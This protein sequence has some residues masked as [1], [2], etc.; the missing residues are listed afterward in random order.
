MCICH[1]Q[2]PME[3]KLKL[4]KKFGPFSREIDTVALFRISKDNGKKLKKDGKRI[5]RP[6]KF[7]DML[8]VKTGHD[9]YVSETIYGDEFGLGYNPYWLNYSIAKHKTT[10]AD[11]REGGVTGGS[12]KLY[13]LTKKKQIGSVTIKQLLD[14]PQCSFLSGYLDFVETFKMRLFAKKKYDIYRDRFTNIRKS[15]VL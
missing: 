6:S 1:F 5:D 8:A 13:D 2:Y 7:T 12:V 14:A 9:Q 11:I 10:I 3:L 4:K 15:L